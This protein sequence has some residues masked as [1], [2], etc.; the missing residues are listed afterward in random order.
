MAIP[1]KFADLLN[2][3]RVGLP[4]VFMRFPAVIPQRLEKSLVKTRPPCMSMYQNAMCRYIQ[5]Y[6]ICVDVKHD[7]LT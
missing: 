4:T 6:Y 1:L 2:F 3:K 5:A 7:S